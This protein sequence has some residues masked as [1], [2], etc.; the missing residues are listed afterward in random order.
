L[1]SKGG[2]EKMS[3]KKRTRDYIM[4]V[5]FSVV[6]AMVV[7]LVA[8]AKMPTLEDGLQPPDPPTVQKAETPKSQEPKTQDKPK[9]V[10]EKPSGFHGGNQNSGNQSNGNSGSVSPSWSKHDSEADP[11]SLRKEFLESTKECVTA[12]VKTGSAAAVGMMAAKTDLKT[13]VGGTLAA[14]VAGCIENRIEETIKLI[15]SNTTSHN[16]V[17]SGPPPKKRA[18]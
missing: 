9:P 12:A 17:L 2:E 3:V 6:L 1:T 16:N 10:I 15:S 14:G 18:R 8:Q 13:L 7:V 11:P 4:V 5:V